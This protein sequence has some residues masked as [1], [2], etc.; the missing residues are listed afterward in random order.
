[1]RENSLSA[2]LTRK[3][4]LLLFLGACPAMA[5]SANVLSALA[6]GVAA[7]LVMLLSNL[8]LWLLRGI[9]GG[10]VLAKLVV[11]SCFVSAVQMLMNAFLPSVYPMMGV[12]LAVLAVSLLLFHEAEETDEGGLGAALGGAVSAGLIFTAA[13]VVM[14]AVR[15]LFGSA[16][17]AGIPVA[18][19]KNYTVPLLAQ[20]PGGFVVFAFVLAV[21]NKLCPAKAEPKGAACEAAGLGETPEE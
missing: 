11:I 2:A 17:F 4:V 8:V 20:A 9:L 7:L 18:A 3:P 15:E 1:M 6:I 12:Y 14:A 16:S 13:V 19:L 21:L 10:S 5:L